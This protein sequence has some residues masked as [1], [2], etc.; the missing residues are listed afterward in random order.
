MWKGLPM[1]EELPALCRSSGVRQKN[2]TAECMGNPHTYTVALFGIL[3][4]IK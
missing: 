1:A 4:R 3:S 2:R